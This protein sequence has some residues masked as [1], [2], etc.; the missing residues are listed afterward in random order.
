MSEMDDDKAPLTRVCGSHP[1]SLLC[2]AI[3][4]LNCFGFE[5]SHRTSTPVPANVEPGGGDGGGDGHG[6]GD[7]DRINDRAKASRNYFCCC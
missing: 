4:T 2:T 6:G 1:P 7:G 3:S 5:G